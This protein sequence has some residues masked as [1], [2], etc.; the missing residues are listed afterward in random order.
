MKKW[1]KLLL[2][3]IAIWRASGRHDL[4]QDLNLYPQDVRL[5]IQH[6]VN[7]DISHDVRHARQRVGY[8]RLQGDLRRARQDS[9]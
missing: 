9:N 1:E 4:N 2:A 3:L 5:D 8:L 7:N 6:G